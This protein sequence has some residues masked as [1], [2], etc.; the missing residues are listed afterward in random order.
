M[1]LNLRRKLLGVPFLFVA[2][3]LLLQLAENAIHRRIQ[4][5]VVYAQLQDQVLSGNSNVLKTAVELQ[6]AN[7]TAR[8]KGVTNREA[9]IAIILEVT[10]PVRF[11]PDGSGYFFC[12]DLSGVRINVPIDK[13]SNGKNMLNL[14]DKR[15]FRFVEAL[16]QATRNGERLRPLPL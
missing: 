4:E 13:A 14:T 9:Q 7:L 2:G 1:K 6:A 10:D 5:K 8:L 12:Y 16:V 15:G 3:L 11:F